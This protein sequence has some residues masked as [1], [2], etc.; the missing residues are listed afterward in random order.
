MLYTNPRSREEGRASRTPTAPPLR[1]DHRDTWW[2]ASMWQI[3]RPAGVSMDLL[4]CSDDAWTIWSVPTLSQEQWQHN[5]RLWTAHVQRVAL[6]NDETHT[7]TQTQC[8]P[9]CL[10]M[11]YITHGWE[12]CFLPDKL[13]TAVA[14]SIVSDINFGFCKVCFSICIIFPHVSVVYWI[15]L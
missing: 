10:R 6:G 4:L 8:L 9:F 1:S 15:G 5:K 11:W 3:Y 12:F 13:S 14:N 2:E 7:Y